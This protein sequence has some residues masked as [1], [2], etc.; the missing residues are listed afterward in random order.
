MPRFG[1][2][3]HPCGK[4]THELSLPELKRSAPGCLSTSLFRCPV[5]EPLQLSLCDTM[6]CGRLL[7]KFRRNIMLPSSGLNV[8]CSSKLLITIYQMT[9]CHI[10]ENCSLNIHRRL[11]LNL[12]RRPLSDSDC[13]GE[14]GAK[15]CENTTMEFQLIS[16]EC[17][18]NV[19]R[20]NFYTFQWSLDGV[21][22]SI[23]NSF[24]DAFA[25]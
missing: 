12:I 3:R 24:G 13:R 14:E 18:L 23:K 7:L 6:Q 21:F 11:N 15:I 5:I 2:S 20:N 17:C 25:N 8:V 19:K 4:V 10:P 16:V 9:L 1:L 22:C